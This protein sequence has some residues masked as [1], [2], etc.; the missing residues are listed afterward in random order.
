MRTVTQFAGLAWNRYCK[1]YPM[2]ERY[3][4]PEIVL[5]TKLQKT[6]GYNDSYENRIILNAKMLDKFPKNM[7]EVIL[8]HEIAH[9]V[10]FNLN[11]WKKYKRHHGKQWQEIMVA[12]GLEPDPY[13][14]MEL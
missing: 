11:G 12:Y 8:P 4:M 7:L 6:A 3:R 1:I 5:S 10:D 9:Q 13:H 2:L 14:T